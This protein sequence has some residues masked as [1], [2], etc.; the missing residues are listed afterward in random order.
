MSIT[1]ATVVDERD[2]LEENQEEG[3]EEIT[4]NQVC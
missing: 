3:T 1:N 4:R 2:R